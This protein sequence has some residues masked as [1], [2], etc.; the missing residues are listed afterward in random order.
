VE[1]S[2]RKQREG[3][4]RNQREHPHAGSWNWAGGDS[5]SGKGVSVGGRAHGARGVS[6]LEGRMVIEGIETTRTLGK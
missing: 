1:T 5:K 6:I 3:M 4:W 2:Q